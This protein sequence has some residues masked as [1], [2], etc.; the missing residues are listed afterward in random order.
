MNHKVL[1]RQAQTT[2][3]A[4]DSETLAD[5]PAMPSIGTL[6]RAP[7]DVRHHLRGTQT[8]TPARL[9]WLEAPSVAR[10]NARAAVGGEQ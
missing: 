1:S 7:D 2:A 10:V 8:H 9:R 6:G 5:P 3:P 4:T